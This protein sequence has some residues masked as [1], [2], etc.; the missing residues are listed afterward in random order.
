MKRVSVLAPAKVNL[1]LH[2]TGRR[3]DGYHLLDSLVAFAPVGDQLQIAAGNVLSLTIEGPE[4]DGVPADM[5]N[6]ALRAAA[7]VAGDTGAA[8]TLVKHLPAAS[9]IGGGSSDAAA[10]LRGMLAFADA[11]GL[12]TLPDMTDAELTP[13]AQDIIALGADVPMCLAAA[14]LRARG[15]GE[16]LSFAKLPAL[17]AV[18]VNPRVPVATPDVFARLQTRENPPM[19]A[20][21]PQ[22]ETAREAISWLA[23]QRNDL[24]AAAI[25]LQPVIEDVL[26]VLR[27]TSGCQLARMSGSGATCFGLFPTADATRAAAQA[28]H[29]SFPAWWVRATWLGNCAEL[30]MPRLQQNMPTG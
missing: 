15:I 17:H 10:A 21:A 4:A 28:I 2:V 12:A 3:G 29:A 19:P 6:L 13:L 22:F 23:L 1:T 30:A 11:P 8:L 18:L 20:A 7:L 25:A 16:S 9:G 5:D 14:P 24:E 26:R 27:G